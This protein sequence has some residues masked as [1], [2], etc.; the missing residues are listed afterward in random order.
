VAS[1]RAELFA[2]AERHD[3]ALSSA[4]SEHLWDDLLILAPDDAEARSHRGEVRDSR[5]AWILQETETARGRRAHLLERARGFLATPAAITPFAA[6]DE[7]AVEWR[8]SLETEDVRLFAAC[9]ASEARS[10]LHHAQAAV[11]LFREVF[12]EV[13]V[14]PSDFTIYLLASEPAKRAFLEKH[15]RADE[16]VRHVALDSDGAWLKGNGALAIWREGREARLEQLVRETVQR[17]LAG[18]YGIGPSQAWAHEGFGLRLCEL[19]LGRSDL[20]VHAPRWSEPS[21]KSRKQAEGLWDAAREVVQDQDMDLGALLAKNHEV[22]TREDVLASYAFACFLMEVHAGRL[23]RLLDE[24][25][26]SGL[27]IEECLEGELRIEL[28]VL[29]RRFERWIEEMGS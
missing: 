10:I 5:G 8:E 18:S 6:A 29:E 2:L 4:E 7:A 27:G 26:R 1:W 28:P 17:M 24:I 25:G 13:P 15:P 14:L 9:D 23:A 20:A 11:D 22:F 3:G 12:D 16:R 19:A 21:V